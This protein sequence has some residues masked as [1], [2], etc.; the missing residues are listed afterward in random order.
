MTSE[1]L[2]DPSISDSDWLLRRIPLS[3]MPFNEARGRRWPSSAAFRPSTGDI[4]VSVYL[5]SELRR[6]GLSTDTVV[7][8]HDGYAVVQFK[9]AVPR[10]HA[11]GVVRDPVVN[12]RRPLTCDPAHALVTGRPGDGRKV[13]QAVGRAVFGHSDTTMAIEPDRAVTDP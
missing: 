3:Q 5:E 9:S 13:W 2:D 1:P 8:S 12:S 7:E 4:E 10:S 6:L 11:R